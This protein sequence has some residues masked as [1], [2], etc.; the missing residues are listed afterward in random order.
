MRIISKKEVEPVLKLVRDKIT[1]HIDE[2]EFIKP[3]DKRI[4]TVL[5]NLWDPVHINI[6]RQMVLPKIE[7]N[8]EP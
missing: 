7:E 4:N 5:L 2:H 8:Y 3:G 1:R 6:Y